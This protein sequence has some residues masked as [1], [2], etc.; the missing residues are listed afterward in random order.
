AG[1]HPQDHD[2]ERDK[3]HD[4]EQR[5]DQ[6][7]LFTDDRENVVIIRR[8]QPRPLRLRAAEAHSEE[9]ASGERPETVKRLPAEPAVVLVAPREP[10]DALES[11]LAR[12][13]EY[14]HGKRAPPQDNAERSPP[15]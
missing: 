11:V 1:E 5:A 14:E 15:D 4:H 13:A 3:H 7:E 8:R 2:G 9:A 10:E 6:S 12:H